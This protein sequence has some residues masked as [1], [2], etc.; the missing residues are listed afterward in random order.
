MINIVHIGQK[1][2]AAVVRRAAEY[3]K[4]DNVI[5]VPTD[6]LYGLACLSQSSEALRKL[7]E[8][9]ARDQSKPVAICVPKPEDISLWGRLTVTASLLDELLPGP[10]TLVFERSER[11]N[12]NLNPGTRLVGVRVPDSPFIRQLTELCSE[13]LALTSANIS[14]AQ[15]TLAV[16]EFSNIWAKV[17]AVYNSGPIP[18]SPVARLGSTVVDLSVP[19]IYH[20]IRDG[21]ARHRT[22]ETLQRHGLIERD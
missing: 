13:P 22:V 17:K 1:Q 9:K 15:S 20:I 12:P 18:D 6:T 5:A 21:C 7:Y 4:G 11:L 8:I 10:V 19:G 14:G 3:L 2:S 16:E